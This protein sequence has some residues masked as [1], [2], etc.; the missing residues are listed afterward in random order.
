[1]TA[2]EREPFEVRFDVMDAPD[3]AEWFD[4]DDSHGGGWW[5]RAGDQ[6]LP[7]EKPSEVSA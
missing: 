6:W 7:I 2:R 4:E 3:G 1:M 5:R